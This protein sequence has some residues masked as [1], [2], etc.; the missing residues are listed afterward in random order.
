[1]DDFYLDL[2]RGKRG[3][4]LVSAALAARGHI[5]TDLS[6]DPEARKNDIDL[7]LVNKQQ[8][9]TT[10]EIKND[11]RSESTGNL[12]IETYNSNNKSHSF[13]GWFF[14][15]AAEYLCFLQENKRTAHIV[16]FAELKK[17]IAANTYRTA[18]SYNASGYL[19]PLEVVKQ[20]PTY[21][22]LAV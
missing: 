1:M 18:N 16:S 11:Q 7:L 6:D 10:L 2:Q 4:K 12:F 8:Q 22:C 9:T 17:N 20:L 14:Y 15:C 5:I 3:E 13:K 19:V 21:F